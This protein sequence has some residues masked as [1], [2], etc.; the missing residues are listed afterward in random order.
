MT[1]VLFQHV[2][3]RCRSGASLEAYLLGSLAMGKLGQGEQRLV[4]GAVV[5]TQKR[6][7]SAS[8]LE[9]ASRQLEGILPPEYLKPIQASPMEQRNSTTP[10]LFQRPSI[11]SGQPLVVRQSFKLESSASPSPQASKS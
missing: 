2:Q 4:A 1:Q 6:P 3:C 10:Q 5:I 9:P 11:H 7:A 8:P